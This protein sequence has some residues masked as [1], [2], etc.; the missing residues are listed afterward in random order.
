MNM[1]KRSYHRHGVETVGHPRLEMPALERIKWSDIKA[2]KP[3]LLE[4]KDWD[5]Y[6]STLPQAEYV[7]ITWTEA[8]WNALDFV[9]C[10][11]DEDMPYFR[12]SH[13]NEWRNKWYKYSNGYEK[14]KKEYDIP[15]Y[16]PSV[17]QDAWGSIFL[18][19]VNGK[20]VL[21][22]KS[23]MHI[24]T[25]GKEMPV[26][27]FVERIVKEASPK[28]LFTIGTAGGAKVDSKLGD[29]SITNAGK[30]ELTGEFKN[31]KFANSTYSNKWQPKEDIQKKIAPLLR[32]VPA[33]QEMMNI[34]V[35]E[36]NNE[37]GT[38]LKW[39]DLKNNDI[40]PN[41]LADAKATFWD[42]DPVLTTNG[43]EIA[44]T[45]GNYKTYVAMD[46]DDAAVAMVCHDF[47]I[48]FGS[49]RNISDPVINAEIPSKKSLHTI[50][51]GWSAKIYS[52]FGFYSSYNGAIATWAAIAG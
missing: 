36:L 2:E 40:E 21:L 6:S 20:K 32:G 33:T 29:V 35:E 23:E 28:T 52:T 48:P 31:K 17:E 24:S 10:D 15:S 8:E 27:A 11:S 46:M 47:G 3:K 16:A 4:I 30:F 25:D 43:Y 38:D 14:A 41:K 22:I 9:F 5:R 39:D 44:T 18:V 51:K 37:E 7:V 34:L 19:E 49:F 45:D 50:Q 42:Q 13:K 12:G 1:E 26:L